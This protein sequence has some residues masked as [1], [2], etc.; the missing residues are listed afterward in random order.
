MKNLLRAAPAKEMKA[1]IGRPT[2][3]SERLRGK[4]DEAR[5]L[6]HCSIICGSLA[7]SE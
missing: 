4:M 7:F 1:R 5:A 3:V 2:P 6:T